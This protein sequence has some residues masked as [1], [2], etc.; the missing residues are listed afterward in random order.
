[1][2]IFPLNKYQSLVSIIHRN[3]GGA[4]WGPEGAAPQDCFIKGGTKKET[5][6][7]RNEKRFN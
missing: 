2:P 1:M 7:K 3:G 4:T 6:Y 5:T